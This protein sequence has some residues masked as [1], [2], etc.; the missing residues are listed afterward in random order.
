MSS[1]GGEM[2]PSLSENRIWKDLS[3]IDVPNKHAKSTCKRGSKLAL[4]PVSQSDPF[5]WNELLAV[6][7]FG[8]N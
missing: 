7:N 4:H 3:K 2:I 8:Y 6:H 1:F 5:Q